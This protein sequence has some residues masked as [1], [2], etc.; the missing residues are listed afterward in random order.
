MELNKE[1]ELIGALLSVPNK[2]AEYPEITE[3]DFS[4]N[5]CK[6]VFS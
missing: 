6:I 5:K 1:E 3:G 2:L 4:N